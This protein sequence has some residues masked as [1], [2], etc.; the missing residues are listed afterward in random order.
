MR[1][2]LLFDFIEVPPEYLATID[3]AGLVDAVDKGIDVDM[4]ILTGHGGKD[5]AVAAI[6]LGVSAWFEK[7]G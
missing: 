6:N 4:L 5:E 1:I 2:H 7:Q 3:K